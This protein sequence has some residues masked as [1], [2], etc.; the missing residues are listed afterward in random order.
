MIGKWFLEYQC[1]TSP[2]FSPDA[3]WE[4]NQLSL[5]ATSKD[6]A[7]REAQE[8]WQNILKEHEKK[9]QEEVFVHFSTYWLRP[10][11]SFI[12]YRI[13]LT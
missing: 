10:T 6:E 1:Q 2:Q 9:R 8:K 7:I 5:N 4:P 11:G 3:G 13:S 12:V